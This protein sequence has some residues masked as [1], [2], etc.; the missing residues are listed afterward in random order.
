MDIINMIESNTNIIYF[1]VGC[2]MDHYNTDDINSYNN[3][4][5]PCFL[6]NIDCKKMIIMIDP[7]MED[8]LKIDNLELVFNIDEKYRLYKKQDLTVY[9]VNNT[10]NYLEHNFNSED[11]SILLSVIS[12]AI[13][14]KIKLI[15][16]DYTGRDPTYLYCNLFD[17]F[18]KKDLLNYVNFDITQKET[19]CYVTFDDNMLILDNKG[20]FVQPK[21]MFLTDIVKINQQ[22]FIINQQKF[23]INQQKFITN[24]RIDILNYEILQSYNKS[25]NENKLE[26]INENKIKYLFAIYNLDFKKIEDKKISLRDKLVL[27]RELII[28]MVN[29]IINSKDCDKSVIEYLINNIK[30]KSDFVN[31]MCIIKQID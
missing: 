22:K 18:N 27:L 30:N 15:F 4:Q 25:N 31:S 5:Y 14:N 12:F 29:D 20:Y 3:Q 13:D 6:Q 2:A 24:Q 21:Y 1:A 7:C 11:Y 17:I 9:V 23:I 19:S 8:D 16:Q 26:I 28:I 10:F